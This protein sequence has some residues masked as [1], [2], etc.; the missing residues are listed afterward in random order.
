MFGFFRK[1]KPTAEF[2]HA[3]A[4]AEPERPAEAAMIRSCRDLFGV[5]PRSPSNPKDRIVLSAD[6]ER[7]FV[8]SGDEL[9]QILRDQEILLARGQVFWG[10]LVQAN[11]ILFQPGNRLMCPAN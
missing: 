4:E 10:Q 7:A 11:K 5:P 8:E 6:L 9:L 1:R 3:A 2:L